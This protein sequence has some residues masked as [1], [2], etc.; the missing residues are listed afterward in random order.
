MRCKLTFGDP[1][2]SAVSRQSCASDPNRIE[3]DRFIFASQHTYEV[4]TSRNTLEIVF[5]DNNN[6]DATVLKNFTLLQSSISAAII[7]AN[8]ILRKKD[9]KPGFHGVQDAA[10]L[11]HRR[12]ISRFTPILALENKIAT[13]F[14]AK[15]ERVSLYRAHNIIICGGTLHTTH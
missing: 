12:K 10:E 14:G 1:V 15:I 7:S 4:C 11:S 2:P 13:E 3:S 6:D 8:T 9:A 5:I